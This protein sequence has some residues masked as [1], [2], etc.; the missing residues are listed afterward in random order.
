MNEFYD[1]TNGVL[2]HVDPELLVATCAR[3]GKV[4]H[5]NAAWR[6]VFA[7]AR[8]P[9]QRLTDED[10]RLVMDALAQAAQGALVTN[11]ICSVQVLERDEPLP[12]LMNFFP[13]HLPGERSPDERSPDE[14]SPDEDDAGESSALSVQAITVTGEVLAEPASWTP[15]QTQRHRMEALGRMTMG[16]AH[17]FNN[18][19]SGLIGHA[20]LLENEFEKHDVPASFK[21]SL[22]TIGQAAVDGASLIEK[23]QRFIRKETQ[24]HFEPLRVPD[25]IQDCL[26]LT[27]PYWYNEPRRQGIV[28]ETTHDF[29][30]VPLVMGSATELREVFVNLILNAVQAMPEGGRLHFSAAFDPQR[31]VVIDV[32]DDGSGMSANVRQHIFEPLFTTKG[33]QGTGMGLAVSYGIVQE[34]EGTITVD[35][36]P[37]EGTRFE[38]VLPPADEVIM[39]DQPDEKAQT[40]SPAHL[41]VVDDEQMVRAILVK[42][43]TLKGHTVEQASSGAEALALMEHN[44]FDIVLT[45]HGMPAMNGR[46]LAQ[47]IRRRAPQQPIVLL[48]GDTEVQE[49]SDVSRLMSKPFKLDELERTI[50][51]LL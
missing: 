27:R 39:D 48:T 37:G 5:R 41:L 36:A 28:I 40:H 16:I 12:V 10:R 31:G 50:Q 42:L 21:E 24:T 38:I 14:R 47:A 2:P 8:D 9:W 34:H 22:G 46:Q 7:A 44:A 32:A 43:L 51:Q 30:N 35:S 18:L 3:E 33:E 45:D 49:T 29:G 25:L 11:Q 15:S 13:V 19:L 1:E 20:E 4:V 23:I 6:S 17:D 26:A